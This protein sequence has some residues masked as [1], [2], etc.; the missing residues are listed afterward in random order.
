MNS[1]IQVYSTIKHKRKPS[2]Y[3]P[4]K[5]WSISAIIW[6]IYESLKRLLRSFY[7]RITEK[8]KIRL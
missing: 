4:T 1:G 8:Y 7:Q 5:H 6:N 2:P 3:S